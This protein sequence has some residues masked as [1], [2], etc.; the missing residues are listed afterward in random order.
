MM[1][2]IYHMSYEFNNWEA[3]HQAMEFVAKRHAE[4]YPTIRIEVPLSVRGS[5]WETLERFAAALRKLEPDD[6]T[7]MSIYGVISFTVNRNE[8][9]NIID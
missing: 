7:E 9:R 6:P 2:L 5:G 1:C 8:N 3:F 4:N